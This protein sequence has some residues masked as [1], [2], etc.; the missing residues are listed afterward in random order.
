MCSMK[1]PLFVD[2]IAQGWLG[3]EATFAQGPR[4]FA[5]QRLNRGP[6]SVRLGSSYAVDMKGDV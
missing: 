3:V 5:C 2:I 6:R 1:H 4:T